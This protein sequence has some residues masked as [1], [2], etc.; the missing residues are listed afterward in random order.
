MAGIDESPLGKTFFVQN[1]DRS[2]FGTYDVKDEDRHPEI[3]AEKPHFALTETQYYSFWVPEANLHCFN[4]IWY[5]P[6]LNSVM[7]GT[8]AWTGVRPESLSCELFNFYQHMSADVFEGHFG[9]A[10][11]ENGF[12]VDAEDPGKRIRIRYLDRERDTHF[13]V[14]QTAVTEP[15]MWPTSNHFEQVM[16]C[17]GEVTLRGQTYPVDCLSVRDRSWGE[18]R[19]ETPMNIPPNHWA[20]GAADAGNSF[21]IVGMED[22]ALDPIWKGRMPAPSSDPLRFGWLIVDGEKCLA[23]SLSMKAE[24]DPVHLMPTAVVMHVEDDRGRKHTIRGRRTAATPFRAWININ[25]SVTL[26]EWEWAGR[27]FTGEMQTVMFG[28]FFNAC[29]TLPES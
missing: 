29:A 4:W 15:L 19:P 18:Y 5:H 20:V 9:K 27:T 25:C 17:T 26:M 21:C 23:R 6:N 2:S 13:D 3:Q 7:A 10:K 11:F 16:H 12:S 1:H 24:F 28:D 22:E 8:M 14:L